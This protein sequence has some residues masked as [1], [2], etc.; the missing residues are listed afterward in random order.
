MRDNSQS[1]TRPLAI[2]HQVGYSTF[3]VAIDANVWSCF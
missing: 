2:L 1:G 3:V